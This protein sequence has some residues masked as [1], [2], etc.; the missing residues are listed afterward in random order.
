M[1]K[2]ILIQTIFIITLLFI[3]PA[4]FAAQAATLKFTPS[5][6]TGSVGQN[7]SLTVD[8]DTGSDG[9][10][11][12]DARFTYPSN[13]VEFVSME[14]GD[15]TNDPFLVIADKDTTELGK[16][17]VAGIVTDPATSQKGQG[18]LVTLTF[19]GKSNGTGKLAFICNAG[20]SSFDSS[21]YKDDIHGTD[22]IVCSQNGEAAITIGQ[23]TT[24]N[25]TA[26][27]TSAPGNPTATPTS[28]AGTQD[29]TATP[30]S[31][32]GTSSGTTPLPTALPKAGSYDNALK[33]IA[34]GSILLL[35]GIGARML[36]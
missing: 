24:T 29:P 25:P 23:G 35:I 9:I 20:D 28:A 22:I 17:L 16:I 8:I 18:T 34:P 21:I 7:F 11:G 13:L 5:S 15:G 10:L 14:D 33:F 27:P 36:L 12:A 19:K 4:V 26:T 31:T 6:I 30:T 3:V 32:S 1:R 2:Q